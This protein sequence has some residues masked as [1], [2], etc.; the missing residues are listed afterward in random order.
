[1]ETLRRANRYVIFQTSFGWCGIVFSEW[2]IKEVHLPEIKKEKLRKSILDGNKNIFEDSLSTKEVIS[3]VCNY[4][5]GNSV[6]FNY[7]LDLK[8]MTGFQKLVYQ[9]TMKI[10]FGSLRTYKWLAEKTGT[11]GGARAIGNALGRNPVPLIIP[12][13][14]VVR[15]DGNLGGFSSPGGIL[16]KKRMLLNEGI[17]IEHR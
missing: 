2:G 12:C 16:F 5:G 14:R 1:M 7:S 17:K 9:E 6:Q 4:F 15:S 8:S 11:P 3:D 10:P 13:H